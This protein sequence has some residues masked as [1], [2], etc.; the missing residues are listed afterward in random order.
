[1]K[2]KDFVMIQKRTGG[3]FLYQGRGAER[4]QAILSRNYGS[5][6]KEN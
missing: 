4:L 5:N 6:I 1:M 3:H 2:A